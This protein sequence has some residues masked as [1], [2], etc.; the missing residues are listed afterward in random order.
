MSHA[1][2]FDVVVGSGRFARMIP[3]GNQSIYP[4]GNSVVVLNNGLQYVDDLYMPPDGVD[5]C[6]FY[7]GRI[8]FN[9]F[10]YSKSCLPDF[11]DIQNEPDSIIVASSIDADNDTGYIASVDEVFAYN[12]TSKANT[13]TFGSAGT[14]NGQFNSI[15]N[16]A[17]YDGEIF[18]IEG[19]LTS[20]DNHR[21]QVFDDAGGYLRQWGSYGE[22]TPGQFEKSQDIAVDDGFVFT[23]QLDGMIQKFDLDG[24]VLAYIS[25]TS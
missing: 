7:G 1:E 5:R 22:N 9:G 4:Q 18:V 20:T 14:G 15:A 25:G 19:S 16:V 24:N 21:V 6:N 11:T 12:L 13:L 17:F 8:Y 10:G 3:V 23:V 2:N